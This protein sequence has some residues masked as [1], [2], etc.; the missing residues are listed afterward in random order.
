[1]QF[2]RPHSPIL[3]APLPSELLKAS[4]L[5]KD[6][7]TQTPLPQE[8]LTRPV[9]EDDGIPDDMDDLSQLAKSN[10]TGLAQWLKEAKSRAKQAVKKAK[11]VSNG[12]KRDKKGRF[13]SRG[14]QGQ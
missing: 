2:P 7:L 13:L 11:K 3:G 9:L 6:Y 8:L 10:P 14:N 5:P 4:P 1:M 12:K